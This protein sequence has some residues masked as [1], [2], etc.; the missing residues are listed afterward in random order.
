MRSS[1]VYRNPCH[2]HNCELAHWKLHSPYAASQ[3]ACMKSKHKA[4]DYLSH[5]TVAD[6]NHLRGTRYYTYLLSN[7]IDYNNSYRICS[8]IRFKEDPQLFIAIHWCCTLLRIFHTGRWLS[9]TKRSSKPY[10]FTIEIR[11]GSNAIRFNLI[12]IVHM[13]Y[14]R[15]VPLTLLRAQLFVA[16]FICT[17]NPTGKFDCFYI[18]LTLTVPGCLVGHCCPSSLPDYIYYCMRGVASTACCL[19]VCGGLL[20][21]KTRHD[22]NLN[23]P[24][25]CICTTGTQSWNDR[26]TGDNSASDPIWSVE[27]GGEISCREHV[28]T[29]RKLGVIMCGPFGAIRPSV[30]F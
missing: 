25:A 7:R 20:P 18:M 27:Y 5:Y 3:P 14:L 13:I 4:H 19:A 9:C 30:F 17:W 12:V 2:H 28:C 21:R 22:W 23:N 29:H 15:T 1:I 8:L 24:R 10:I 11:H 6:R 16:A 26:L